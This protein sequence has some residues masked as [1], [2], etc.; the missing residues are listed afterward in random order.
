MKSYVNYAIL[1]CFFLLISCGVSNYNYPKAIDGK[2]DLSSWNDM[3]IYSVKL[4][5]EWEFYP[6]RYI[7]GEEFEKPENSSEKILITVPSH[8]GSYLKDKFPHR[9]NVGEA[10]GTFR[11]KIIYPQNSRFA[12][13]SSWVANAFR[14]YCGK[15]LLLTQ[16]TPG[17]SREDTIPY[18]DYFSVNLTDCNSDE[19]VFH[20]ANFN[21][22]LGGL[23]QPVTLVRDTFQ[24]K[25]LMKEEAILY[26]LVSINLAFFLYHFLL[27]VLR[28]NDKASLFFSFLCIGTCVLI[29]TSE[30]FFQR[31][32]NQ[33]IFDLQYRLEFISIPLLIMANL[34]FMKNLFP[35][36]IS[37]KLSFTIYSIGFFI[38]IPF[39][40]LPSV[41]SSYF[42]PYMQFFVFVALLT[43]IAIAILARIRKRRL[44]RAIIFAYSL[45]FLCVLYDIL[46]LNGFIPVGMR[47]MPFGFLGVIFVQ[48]GAIAGLFTEAYHTAEHLSNNLKE[49]V[50]LKTKE[51]ADANISI[52]T[53]YEQKT[54]FFQNISHELRTPLTL[55]KGPIQAAIRNQSPLDKEEIEMIGRNSNRLLQLVNQLLDLQKI[56][57]GQMKADIKPINLYLFLKMITESFSPYLKSKEISITFTP[58][59]DALYVLADLDKLEKCID[60]YISNAYKFTP[61]KGKIE[62]ITSE[63]SNDKNQIQVLVKDNG[64]GIPYEKQKF[65]FSRFGYSEISLSKDQEGTG[66]GLSLVKQL[67]E[68]MNGSVGYSSVAGEGSSFWFTLLVSEE[69]IDSNPLDFSLRQDILEFSSQKK[70]KKEELNYE[71]P[72]SNEKILIVDDNSDLRRYIEKL[73]GSEGYMIITAFDGLDGKQK[74]ENYNPDLIITDLMMPRLSGIDMIKKLRENILFKTTPILLLTAKAEEETRKEVVRAG[75]DGYLSKPFDDSELVVTV[76]NLLNLK[77]KEKLILKDLELARSVQQNLLPRNDP[78]VHGLSFSSKYIPMVE[79]GGDY[80]DYAIYPDDRVGIFIADVSGHGVSAAMIGA[81]LKLIFS[82]KATSMEPAEFLSYCNEK[83]FNNIA[84]QFITASYSVISSN[85]KTLK[86]AYAGHPPAR[87]IRNGQIQHLGKKG[88]PLGILESIKYEEEIYNLQSED[89]LFF[90][91]D[92]LIEIT[93]SE[94]NTW[95]ED[96]LDSELLKNKNLPVSDILDEVIRSGLEFRGKELSSDDIT[97]IGM[98]VL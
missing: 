9:E 59:S 38:S 22:R 32:V 82:N 47:L 34:A 11:L 90:L 70:S 48:A 71:N 26:V 29:F 87:L 4:D 46:M 15:K 65:L 86:I 40:I 53:A 39:A 8:W 97:L 35:Q 13:S 19:I 77:S 75:A 58:H 73:L 42:V 63:F 83:L 84:A 37:Y 54:A 51:L 68:L 92:G 27:W 6:D 31:L 33:N 60:N 55:I 3:S 44:S 36:E 93:D 94:F 89:L 62:I 88:K 28:R 43:V 80:Y 41:A 57:S 24:F 96:A 25:H 64:V 67:V 78:S 18:N 21:H 56:T 14:L 45:A 7:L 85:R 95:D 91:T 10:Y 20:I 72:K 69:H 52:Q 30:K 49:E 1:I 66:L 2:I 12:I 50:A 61:A 76:R 74:A 79:V 23:R 5:G 16:G 81:M 98:K 17:T